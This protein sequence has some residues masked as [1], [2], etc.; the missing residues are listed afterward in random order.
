MAAVTL[1][2][3]NDDQV[4]L[5]RGVTGFIREQEFK[6]IKYYVSALNPTLMYG[7]GTALLVGTGVGAGIGAL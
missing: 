1:K 3:P 6:K 2:G 4:D 7:A 5:V